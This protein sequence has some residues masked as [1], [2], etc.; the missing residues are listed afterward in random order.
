MYRSIMNSLEAID[1]RGLTEAAESLGAK[2]WRVLLF[3]IVP[4]IKS[5]VVNGALLVFSTVLAEFTLANLLVGTRLKTF[6]IY[7]VEFTRF[8]A[9]QASALAVISFVFAWV[10]SL[11]VLWLAAKGG[12]PREVMGAR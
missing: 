1:A 7:L 9:R 12:R 5:G 6:P 4:N 8:D 11:L 2:P 10:I 3:V